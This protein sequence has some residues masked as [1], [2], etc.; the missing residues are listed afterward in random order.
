MSEIRIP[1]SLD[2]ARARRAGIKTNT[3]RVM[4]PQPIDDD[5]QVHVGLF[6][7]TVYA[8]HGEE[9]PAEEA[10]GAWTEGGYWSA[11]SPY[12]QPGDILLPVEPWRA[13]LEFDAMAPSEIPAGTPIWLDADGPAPATFG[14]YRHAR[15]MPKA[16]IKARDEVIEVRAER[17]HDISEDDAV[18]EGLT[19]SAKARKSESCMGI[20]ECR[21]PDGKIHFDVNACDLFRKLWEQINGP[22]S[23]APNPYVW[24]VRFKVLVP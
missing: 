15:F 21:L 7:P 9:Q 16:L 2:M 6:H 11:R 1:Y 23:W 14:R 10:F 24:V 17:L 5:G 18:A 8:R 3:R 20:Y 19:F 22:G 13:P 4:K 12:G